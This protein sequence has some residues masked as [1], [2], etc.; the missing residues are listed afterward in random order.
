LLLANVEMA[1]ERELLQRLEE[2]RDHL[3]ISKEE[4]AR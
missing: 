1:A 4:L 3:H 2:A